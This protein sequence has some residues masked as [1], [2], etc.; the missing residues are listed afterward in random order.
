MD[1]LICK[2]F[3]IKGLYSKIY[4]VSRDEF[5]NVLDLI[6][7]KYTIETLIF[8]NKVGLYVDN[9]LFGLIKIGV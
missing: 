6:A 5:Y 7:E 4:F 1:Y 2:D 8:E 9:F 3:K